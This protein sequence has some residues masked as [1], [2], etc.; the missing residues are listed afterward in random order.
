MNEWGGR[1]SWKSIC[2]RHL[3]EPLEG[4]LLTNSQVHS[5]GTKTL[6]TGKRNLKGFPDQMMK[7]IVG[8]A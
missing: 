2:F 8:A 3:D 1:E 6:L 4:M 7:T 5:L